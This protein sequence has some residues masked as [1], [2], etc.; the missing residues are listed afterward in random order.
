MPDELKRLGRREAYRLGALRTQGVG[1]PAPPR[2]LQPS[3]LPRHR[4]PASAWVLGF[5]AGTAAVAAAAEAGLWFMPLLVGVLAG[6]C[7]RLGRWRPRVTLPVAAAMAVIGWGIPLGLAAGRGHAVGA[8]VLGLHPHTAVSVGLLL[9]TAAVQAVAGAWLGRALAPS[10]A[11][12]LWPL[13]RPA[14]GA[15][16]SRPGVTGTARVTDHGA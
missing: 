15:A 6:L 16:R 14:T 13:T 5:V 11:A 12:R 7:G 2:G 8:A 1:Q 3:F 4:G 9:V 10:V